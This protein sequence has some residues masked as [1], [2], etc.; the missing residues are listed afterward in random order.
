MERAQKISRN[1]GEI[2]ENE[3]QT[4]KKWKIPPK[5]NINSISLETSSETCGYL[6]IKGDE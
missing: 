4:K 6:S 3:K 1:T 2:G 5:T